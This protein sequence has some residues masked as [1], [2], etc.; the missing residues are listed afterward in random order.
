MKR[1]KIREYEPRTCFFC[2]QNGTAEALERHHIFEGRTGT[3]ELCD[4]YG[5][6]VDLCGETCHRNGPKSAHKCR[7][8]A[9]LLHKYGQIKWMLSTGGTEEEFRAL[10]LR[11]YLSDGE[12]ESVR[13]LQAAGVT[14]FEPDFGGYSTRE[15]APVPFDWAC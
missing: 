5:L 13:A 9:K 4:K 12:L 1:I 2:G 6:Y 14:E 7:E 8:T 10:F 3:R 11:N 15:G